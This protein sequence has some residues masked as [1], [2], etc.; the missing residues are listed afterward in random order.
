M[1]Q[2]SHGLTH[3]KEKN[4]MIFNSKSDIISELSK[5]SICIDCGVSVGNI[6]HLFA[7]KG[8]VVYSF[9]PDQMC[10]AELKKDLKSLLI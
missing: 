5:N 9:E 3:L 10:Y 7:S 8:A 6:T 2:E 1:H 4:L